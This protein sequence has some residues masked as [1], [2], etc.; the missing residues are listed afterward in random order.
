MFIGAFDDIWIK[1]LCAALVMKIVISVIGVFVPALAGENDVVEIISIVLAIA[2][3]TGFI[4][5]PSTAT[6]PEVRHYRKNTTRL[7]QKS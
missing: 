1:V 5:Y 7:M 3:A 2:L 4:H 6:V